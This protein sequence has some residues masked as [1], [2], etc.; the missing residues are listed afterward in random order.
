MYTFA[1][2]LLRAKISYKCIL[3]RYICLFKQTAG[4][5]GHYRLCSYSKHHA[6]HEICFEA[7]L[8]EVKQMRSLRHLCYRFATRE[9][10]KAQL[11]RKLSSAHNVQITQSQYTLLHDFLPVQ[12]SIDNANHAGVSHAYIHTYIHTYI[13]T[14][15]QTDRQTYINIYIF[16]NPRSRVTIQDAK[17]VSD[18]IE[19]GT[20]KN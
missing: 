12:V 19:K 3:L 13:Q 20:K 14:D 16:I 4:K 5:S 7:N 17:T 1:T 9:N 8:V 10:P 6:K 15:R 11:I 18:E 2:H